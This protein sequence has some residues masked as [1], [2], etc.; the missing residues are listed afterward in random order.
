MFGARG[1]LGAMVKYPQSP[2]YPS[3][4]N[5]QPVRPV[6]QELARETAA[7]F[8]P[9]LVGARDMLNIVPSR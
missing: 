2:Y 8:L 4:S 5:P 9:A 6:L 7:T 3:L 1:G